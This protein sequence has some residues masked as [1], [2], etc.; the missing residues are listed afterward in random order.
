MTTDLF[1]YEKYETQHNNIN[2]ATSSKILKS[3]LNHEK[4]TTSLEDRWKM[5]FVN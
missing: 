2:T 1:V 3:C 5:G 4:R